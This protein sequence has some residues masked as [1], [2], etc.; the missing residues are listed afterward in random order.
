MKITLIQ[1]ESDGNRKENEEKTFKYLNKAIKDFPDIICLSELF[2]SWG[3]DFNSGIIDIDGI[4]IYQ[5]FAKNNKV[6]LILGSVALKN[7]N[8]NSNKTTNTCFVI[9]RDGNIIGRY[10]K[11]YMYVVNRQDLKL[12]EREDT[13]PGKN[14]GLV[15]IENVKIGIGICFDLRFPEYFRELT[16]NGANIIFLPAHF[17]ENTGSKAWNILPKARAMENQ[18]YFCACNQTGEGLC[19]NSKV[20]D[21]EGNIVKELGKGEDILT[22][23]L[24]LN[25]QEKYRREFP[26]LDQ[27]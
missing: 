21:Y 3:K 12:D 19:G 5:E 2:L 4:E 23:E 1:M 11:K 26:V 24:Y 10:D 25:K 20:I 18:I 22:V 7:K 17:R 15:E 13:I 6:N 27:I 9:N 16:K 8:K 14:I